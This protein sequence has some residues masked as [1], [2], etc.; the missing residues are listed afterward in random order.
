MTVNLYVRNESACKRL[1][2]R[3][4]LQRIAQRVCEGEGV[5]DDVEVS[6]L[7]CGDAFIQSLN[8]EYRG[9]DRPTDVLAFAQDA[10]PG[11]GAVCLG[12]I[13]ISLETVG[14]NCAG[15]RAVMRDEVRLL[16]CHG[17]LHLLGHDHATGRDRKQMAAKQALYLGLGSGDAWPE[18]PTPRTGHGGRSRRGGLRHFGR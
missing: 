8:R 1:C 15:D 14:R 12:D 9:T 4:G 13:V 16:L 5:R 11:R 6:V 7:L 17:L 2:Q 3:R 10:A 18:A